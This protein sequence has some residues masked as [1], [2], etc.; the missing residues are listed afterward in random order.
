MGCRSPADLP[1]LQDSYVNEM[2]E[3]LHDIW[4]AVKDTETG[5]F[6]AVSNWRLYTNGEGGARDS[7]APRE[8]LDAEDFEKS[9]KIISHTNESRAKS[10][11]GPFLRM[12]FSVW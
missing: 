12:F 6:V 9:R 4:I 2:R 8:W 5:K 11:P 1:R 7:D 3:N 10:M